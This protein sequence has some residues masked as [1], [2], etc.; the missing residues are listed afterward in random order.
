MTMTP[1]KLP[2]T[3]E[4]FTGELEK[5]GGFLTQFLVFWQQSKTE[6]SDY[7]KIPCWEGHW[8]PTVTF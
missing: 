1:E 2:S 6:S 7:A 8:D 3:P 5:S 4:V